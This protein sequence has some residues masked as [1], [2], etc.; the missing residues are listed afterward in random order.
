VV[1]DRFGLGAD[2]RAA[3]DQV[4]V[5]ALG[6]GVD[7]DQGVDRLE[8]YSSEV[9]LSGAGLPEDGSVLAGGDVEDPPAGGLLD[10]SWLCS[11]LASWRPLQPRYRSARPTA[12][13]IRLCCRPLR[14]N[15]KGRTLESFIQAL[16]LSTR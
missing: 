14:H 7:D 8:D 5:L 11:W 1:E 12:R 13:I 16:G 4:V 2:H 10:W 6:L 3:L 15:G 9:G